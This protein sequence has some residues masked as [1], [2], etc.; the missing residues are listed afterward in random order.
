MRSLMAALVAMTI[1]C[2]ASNEP[3]PAPRCSGRVR[4]IATTIE[5]PE[6]TNATALLAARRRR[7]ARVRFPTPLAASIPPDS[8]VTAFTTADQHLA[9]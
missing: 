7:C 2:G 9:G 6:N 1:A 4:F 3:A 8:V 5:E